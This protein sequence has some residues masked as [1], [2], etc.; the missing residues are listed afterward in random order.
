[1]HIPL[2]LMAAVIVWS[3]VGK[4]TDHNNTAWHVVNLLCWFSS[5]S[6]SLSFSVCFLLNQRNMILCHNRKQSVA[7]ACV[8]GCST[9]ASGVCHMIVHD[10]VPWCSIRAYGYRSVHVHAH[11]STYINTLSYSIVRGGAQDIAGASSLHT[12]W[13]VGPSFI[14]IKR[15][16]QPSIIRRQVPGINKVWPDGGSFSKSEHSGW[17]KEAKQSM[18][19]PSI[20]SPGSLFTYCRPY[21]LCGLVVLF[22]WR[23]C[24]RACKLS[25]TVRC[26]TW[27][28]KE[29]RYM[30][31]YIYIYMYMYMYMY[32]YILN[33]INSVIVSIVIIVLI[34]CRYII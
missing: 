5:L 26:K 25:R 10:G 34:I 24:I 16:R 14:T 6:V 23:S 18:R 2:V 29:R 21:F 1:M 19:S 9:H 33:V 20:F 31:I 32:M 11:A 15:P 17:A 13:F 30:Y 4:R 3:N 7:H 28:H 22:H 12:L 27:N 8:R